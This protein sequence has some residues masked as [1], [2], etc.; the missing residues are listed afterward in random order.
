M[1]V[2]WRVRDLEYHYKVKEFGNSLRFSG[3]IRMNHCT[4]FYHDRLLL[5]KTVYLISNALLWFYAIDQLLCFIIFFCFAGRLFLRLSLHAFVHLI[6]HT[7]KLFTLQNT[8]D[9]SSRQN[10]PHSALSSVSQVLNPFLHPFCA[11]TH[12][13]TLFHNLAVIVMY[14]FSCTDPL[15]SF[16]S[17]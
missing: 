2:N 6:F 16:C 3:T 10:C 7:D 13:S 12:I 5:A 8:K 1:A 9:V 17:M 4:F 11:S 15:K 14:S